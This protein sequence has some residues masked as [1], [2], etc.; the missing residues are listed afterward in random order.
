MKTRIDIVILILIAFVL[1][2]LSTGLFFRKQSLEKIRDESK[3]K[4]WADKP[5]WE[6]EYN[7]PFTPCVSDK[8][9]FRTKD[10]MQIQFGYSLLIDWRDTT[11]S[12]LLKIEIEQ[13]IY[14]MGF[15]HYAE[16]F[17]QRKI[18]QVSIDSK[19]YIQMK[20]TI[21][22]LGNHSL[23]CGLKNSSFTYLQMESTFKK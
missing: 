7:P 13:H 1:G 22:F 12:K 16:E 11:Y 18:D 2:V 19:I 8:I 3:E 23:P 5:K 15:E 9:T 21:L 10:G 6:Y 17:F 4:Y 20:D 14:S